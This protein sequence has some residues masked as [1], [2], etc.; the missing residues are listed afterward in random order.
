[1]LNKREPLLLFAGAPP[2]GHRAL[3]CRS[4]S[5]RQR[6]ELH[7][8]GLVAVSTALHRTMKQSMSKDAFL[9]FFSCSSRTFLQRRVTV[10]VGMGAAARRDGSTVQNIAVL[11]TVVVAQLEACSLKRGTS[12]SDQ[13]NYGRA[14]KGTM[15]VATAVPPPFY[16]GVAPN[17]VSA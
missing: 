17:C 6:K 12:I 15:R 4:A 11:T 13:S 7:V 2:R 8:S 5:K 1:M 14:V 9:F 3:D 10:T 16:L